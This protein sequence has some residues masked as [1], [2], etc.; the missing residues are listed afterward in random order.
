MTTYDE[1]DQ[2]RATTTGLDD[3]VR[4]WVLSLLRGGR[5]TAAMLRGF[6]R[7]FG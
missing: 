4:A 6:E 3:D 5:G 7:L 1:S 2:Y